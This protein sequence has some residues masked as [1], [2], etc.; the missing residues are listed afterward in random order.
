MRALPR[1]RG[2][3]LFELLV[4]IVLIGISVALVGYGVGKGLH[5]ASERRALSEVVQAL[6]AAR[7]QAI[8]TGQPAQTRFD[9][10]DGQF[11]GPL[12]KVRRLPSDM[13]VQLQT[14]E[15]LGSAFE[16]Y[17]DG[18]ASGGHVLL[19]RND[20]RWRVDINWLTGNVQLRA[21]N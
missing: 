11:Q 7:V 6:R 2:F 13:H 9:L 14:A 16:F 20:K 15:G 8:V 17:P 1:A 12:Q 21:L 3:T 18:G 4:V 19:T 10:K 5:A